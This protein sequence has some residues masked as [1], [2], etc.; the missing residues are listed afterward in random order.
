MR[1]MMT[2]AEQ[3]KVVDNYFDVEEAP[4]GI[5]APEDEA[6]VV[7]SGGYACFLEWKHRTP[8]VHFCS[9]D[10]AENPQ[11]FSLLT[12]ILE[13]AVGIEDGDCSLFCDYLQPWEEVTGEAVWVKANRYTD[14][15]LDEMVREQVADAAFR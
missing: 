14:C 9:G 7:K 3:G 5:F 1:T 2:K 12:N 15:Y 10:I 4:E 13:R 11:F 8:I 6:Y